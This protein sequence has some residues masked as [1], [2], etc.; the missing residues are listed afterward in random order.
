MERELKATAAVESIA[1]AA[2]AAAEIEKKGRN[3]R[4]GNIINWVE[5]RR[6]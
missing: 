5:E 2:A 6:V 4:I 1:A 3:E